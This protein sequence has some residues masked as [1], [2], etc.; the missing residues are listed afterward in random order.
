MAEL[1]ELEQAQPQYGIAGQSRM[2]VRIVEQPVTLV[3]CMPGR[4]VVSIFP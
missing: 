4:R 2:R 3:R 1:A